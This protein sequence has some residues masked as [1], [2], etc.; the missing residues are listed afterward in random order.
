[1]WWIKQKLGPVEYYSEPDHFH[2]LTEVD[3]SMLVNAPYTDDKPNGKGYVFFERL[4]REVERWFP[5]MKTAE[6]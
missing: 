5:S 2:S 1:M 4:K 6:S 3:L